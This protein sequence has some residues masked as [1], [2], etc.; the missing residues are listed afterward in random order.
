M[1][2]FLFVCLFA[3]MHASAWHFIVSIFDHLIVHGELKFPIKEQPFC[4]VTGS[5]TGSWKGKCTFRKRLLQSPP[6]SVTL[7]V[8]HGS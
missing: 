2:H 4:L 5:F 1:Q 8:W 6:A 3:Y 7:A